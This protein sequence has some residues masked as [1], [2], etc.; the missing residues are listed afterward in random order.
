MNFSFSVLF[1]SFFFSSLFII[2][3]FWCQEMP[4]FQFMTFLY[5]GY[6]NVNSSKIYVIVKFNYLFIFFCVKKV[7][8]KF[9][10]FMFDGQMNREELNNV[11]T[12]VSFNQLKRCHIG[13]SI[14]NSC[15]FTI[16]CVSLQ[17]NSKQFHASGI[18][19]LVFSLFLIFFFCVFYVVTTKSEWEYMMALKTILFVCA[20]I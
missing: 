20:E 19:R 13:F 15:R 8:E 11:R 6:Q 4:F 1:R 14:I 17:L 16:H 3:I 10:P 12:L 5:F 9:H 18:C 2:N 7:V